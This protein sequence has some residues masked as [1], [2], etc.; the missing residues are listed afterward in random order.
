[1]NTMCLIKCEREKVENII[2]IIEEWGGFCFGV[3]KEKGL[4]MLGE[5]RGVFDE[6]KKN[7]V[8]TECVCLFVEIGRGKNRGEQRSD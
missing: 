4:K 7:D 8:L 6:E 5:D 1:M 2:V 3:K